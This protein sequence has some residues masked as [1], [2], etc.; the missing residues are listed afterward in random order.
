MSSTFRLEHSFPDIPVELF[1]K[2][3][4]HP[5]LI[6]MLSGMPGFRSRDLHERTIGVS[7]LDRLR[8]L[9]VTHAVV[10]RL[11]GSARVSGVVMKTVS[12]H[13]GLLVVTGLIVFLL[14]LWTGPMYNQIDQSLNSVTENLPDSVLAL[15]GFADESTPEGWLTGEMFSMTVPIA[16]IAIGVVIGARAL[17][18]EERQGTMSLLLASP[19]SRTRIVLD[20]AGAMGIHLAAIGLITFAGVMLGAVIGELGVGA[21]GIAS[22]TL[23]AVLLGAV[24]GSVALL[25]GAATGRVSTAAYGAAGGAVFAYIANAMLSLSD[26]LGSFAKLS[27]F[28]YYLTGDPL[29]TGLVLWHAA[30][31]AGLTALLVATSVLLFNRRDLR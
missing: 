8:E 2:Y 27:P 10:E 24:F 5:E 29:G 25:I 30:L 9:P 17:A 16:T 23:L 21:G 11:E 31:L 12:A 4:N 15:I 19:V 3:L 26:T 6:A 13:R 14:G 18:G 28:Y 1:E 7:L 22:I 20:K